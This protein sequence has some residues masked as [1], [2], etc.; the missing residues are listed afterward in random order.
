MSEE[1]DGSNKGG[2][3]ED[4]ST[5]GQ[6]AST[7]RFKSQQEAEKAYTSLEK[8]LGERVTPD[9]N[10]MSVSEKAKLVY[11]DNPQYKSDISSELAGKSRELSSQFGLPSELV[12]SILKSVAG[13]FDKNV[14]TTKSEEK[15]AYLADSSNVAALKTYAIKSGRDLAQLQIDINKGKVPLEDI[16]VYV[17]HGKMYEGTESASTISASSAVDLPEEQ[18][19]AMYNNIINKQQ[20]ILWNAAHPEHG[21]VVRVYKQLCKQLGATDILE[22]ETIDK[23]T[24]KY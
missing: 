19:A 4:G 18:A 6:L 15:K 10:N 21:K 7:S 9:Y 5:E 22:G 17:E 20:N 1:G 3:L 24:S 14:K 23:Y 16:Q 11:G 8:K 13:E 2:L 12:D